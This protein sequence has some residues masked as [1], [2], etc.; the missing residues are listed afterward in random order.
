MGIFESVGAAWRLISEWDRTSQQTLAVTKGDIEPASNAYN[1]TTQFLTSLGVSYSIKWGVIVDY[2]PGVNCYKVHSATDG[3]IDCYPLG[4]G[5]YQY[6]SLDVKTY[7]LDTV[8]LY[9]DDGGLSG[10]WIIG[11]IPPF[12]T[13]ARKGISD[14]ILQGGFAGLGV[15]EAHKAP[16]KLGGK[17]AGG[18]IADRSARTPVDSIPG[19]FCRISETGVM[20]YQDSFM[21][22]LRVDEMCGIFVYYWDQLCRIAGHNFQRWTCGSELESYDDEGEHSFYEG[23]ATYPW[24]QLAQLHGPT[25]ASTTNTAEDVQLENQHRAEIEPKHDDLQPFH[26][27]RRWSG[28]LGQGEKRILCV[29]PEDGELQRYEDELKIT[30]L[31]EDNI[32]LGGMRTIRTA[33]GLFICK[34]PVIPV[35]KRVQKH[36]SQTGDSAEN[37][38]ASGLSAYGEGEDHKVKAFP[39]IT[40]DNQNLAAIAGILDLQAH[41][42]NWVGGHAFHYHEKDYN[43]PEENE[44]EEISTNQEE[45][46]FGS[47]ANQWYLPLP[48]EETIKVD[49]RED[50]TVTV[51]RNSSWFALLPDGGI[52]FADGYGC[53]ISSAAG[54]LRISAPGDIFLDAGRNVMGWAGRDVVLRAK[55]STDI[56]CTDGDFRVKAE[57]NV[58]MIAANGGGQYGMLL[59]SRSSSEDYNFD[60]PGEK[61]KCSGIVLRSAKSNIVTWSKNAYIRTGGGGISPGNIVLDA[62]SGDSLIITRSKKQEHFFSNGADS[63][64]YSYFGN[65]EAISLAHL[66]TKEAVLFGVPLWANSEI[67]AAGPL[68]IKGSVYAVEGDIRAQNVGDGHIQQLEGQPLANR[69]SAVSQV[70]QREDEEKKIGKKSYKSD[71]HTPWYEKDKAGHEDT[72]EKGEASLRDKDQYKCGD[73]VLYESYWQQL[74]RLGSG[75]PS[76]WSENKVT[77]GDKELY[78]FPGKERWVKQ[79][80]FQEL[81]TELFDVSTGLSKDRGSAYEDAEITPGDL[82]VLDGNYPIVG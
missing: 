67:V 74:A 66:V 33:T 7:G 60:D 64:S 18:G 58:Q 41:I 29:P 27:L 71:V 73:F 37:Y 17:D 46:S 43:Y 20:I 49:H 35:P 76:T 28:Y 63:G 53:S 48:G 65:D 78:P 23:I 26:R 69:R 45:A 10:S 21:A 72:I 2:V 57:K 42:F 55:N 54:S 31:Y 40:G 32:T 30:G 56:T 68:T 62:N 13:D 9:V 70:S 16:F 38:K 1:S 51:Y 61:T 5:Q 11:S 25:E 24:E 15:E 4:S 36:A 80:A 22:A 14:Y 82:K 47:L 6:G 77:F 81:D 39:E 50:G 75:T 59:E 44:M 79:P 3:V 12:Q 34:R 52:Q 19:A 8:I